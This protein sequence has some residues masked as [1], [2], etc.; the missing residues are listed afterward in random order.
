MPGDGM[1][2]L[3]VT[4]VPLSCVLQSPKSGQPGLA[5]EFFAAT[6]YSEGE[7]NDPLLDSTTNAIFQAATAHH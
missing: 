1:W 4:S 3:L 2:Q 7:N 5:D 6:P